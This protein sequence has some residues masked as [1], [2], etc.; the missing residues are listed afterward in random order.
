MTPLPRRLLTVL[1]TFLV[2][3]VASAC[4]AETRTAQIEVVPEVL[5]LPGD[6]VT[7]FHYLP[8]GPSDSRFPDQNWA[9]LYMPAGNHA[10]NSVPLV[11]L[12]HGGGWKS[13]MGAGV[14]DGLARELAGRG[15]A[16]YNIEYRRVGSG[17]GWPTTFDDVARAMDYVAKLTLR[18][19]QLAA[20]DAL[21]VGHSAGAQ[22]AV[23]ASTRHDLHGDEVGSRPLFRPTRV[24]S[25]AG[26]LDMVYAANRG[27]NHIVAVLGGRPAEVPQRYAS[28]DPIQNLD[29]EVP[30]IAV[31]GTLDTV[32]SPANSQRYVAALKKRGG[33]ASLEMIPGENHTSIVST[34]SPGFKRVLHLITATSEA[35]PNQLPA[36]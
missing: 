34:R 33:R 36:K 20:D 19:P 28:V 29:P 11:V 30:V 23:W 3:A 22:L 7:R 18:Y 21:V 26:P 5:T 9:D 8:D 24:I 27:D 12:I 13:T 10:F 35:E 31:H 4:A 16:V 17:G 25:L 6:T 14:L 15:M 1:A 2:A 32:V